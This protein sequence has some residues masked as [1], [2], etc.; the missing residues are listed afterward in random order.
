ME[1]FKLLAS[2][3]FC[4]AGRWKLIS[5]RRFQTQSDIRKGVWGK[6]TE[7]GSTRGLYEVA[8]QIPLQSSSIY[9]WY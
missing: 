4:T 6:I 9:Y 2:L 5:D 3:H 7:G 1:N 8:L